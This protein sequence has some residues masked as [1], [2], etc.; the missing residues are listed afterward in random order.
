MPD[1][2]AQNHDHLVGMYDPTMTNHGILLSRVSSQERIHS[3][4][5]NFEDA[6]VVPDSYRFGE[7][8]GGERRSK[9]RPTGNWKYLRIP[10]T[11]DSVKCR[12]NHQ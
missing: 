5:R 1:T 7:Y 9:R 11:G 8:E 2:A 6:G 4:L 3:L 10:T 12:E